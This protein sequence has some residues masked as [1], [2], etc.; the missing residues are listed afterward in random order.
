MRRGLGWLML[1]VLGACEA[2]DDRCCEDDD[3]ERPD[4][5]DD[6][7][8]DDTDPNVETD[9]ETDTDTET[10]SPVDTGELGH[11]SVLTA[12]SPVI[13]LDPELRDDDPAELLA[14]D[15]PEPPRRGLA[16]GG[17]AVGDVNGDGRLDLVG[18]VFDR[19]AVWTQTADRDFEREVPWNVV[20]AGNDGGLVGVTLVDVDDDGDLDVFATGRGVARTLLKNDGTGRFAFGMDGSGLGLLPGDHGATGQA[21]GDLDGDGDLDLVVGGHGPLPADVD[22]DTLDVGQPTYLFLQGLPGVFSDGRSRLPTAAHDGWTLQPLLIDADEDGDDDLF[23]ANTFADLIEPS[24]LLVNDGGTFTADDGALGWDDDRWAGGAAAGDLDGDGVEDL[25]VGGRA[26]VVARLSSTGWTDEAAAL[27]LAAP[28]GAT[29]GWGPSIGD[30]NNDGLNDLT[31]AFSD[32]EV[33]W[34]P[35]VVSQRDVVAVQRPDGTFVDASDALAMGSGGPHH[36]LLWAD[37]DRDGWLDAIA[38]GLDGVLRVA[39]AHCGE[40]SWVTVQLRQGAPNRYA[41]GATVW[42]EAGGRTVMG[43]VRTGSGFGASG[44][45]EVHLGLGSP[46]QIDKLTVRWP[47]GVEEVWRNVV[48]RRHLTVS[49]P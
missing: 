31:V 13:C 14:I 10:D 1:G 46:R 9:P 48:A 17:L 29:W 21:W 20:G 23:L 24:R 38:M 27:G 26:S 33:D 2:S 34:A 36:N 15:M 39:F 35:S 28:A 8:T 47:D 11:S 43:R 7:D 32:Y 22:L 49:R 44:P 40:A 42:A 12:S 45:P 25:A 37:L 41:V 5:T 4:L 19:V 30:V 16:G 6:T 3:T 18:G